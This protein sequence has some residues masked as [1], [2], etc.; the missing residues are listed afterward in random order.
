MR[1]SD[2]PLYFKAEMR[3]DAVLLCCLSRSGMAPSPLTATFASLVPAILMPQP[4]EQ[5]GLQAHTTTPIETGFCHVGQAGLKLLVSSDL[6]T[7]ASQSAG[8]T[9][10]CAIW[11]G[12]VAPS[13]L[14]GRGR[15]ITQG[16]EFQTS[17]DNTVK[18]HFY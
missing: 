13:T 9:E 7:L 3:P 6:P 8:I 2:E 15:R 16:Q 14:G 5:L 11:S 4:P 1:Q 17:L 12:A 10:R 18:P